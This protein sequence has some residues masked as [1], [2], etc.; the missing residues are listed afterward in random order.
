MQTGWLL[1]DGQVLAAADALDR[2]SDRAK[3][4]AGHP[5]FDGALLLAPMKI[6]HSIGVAFPLDVAFC[7]ADLRVLRTIHLERWRL[8]APNWACH[9]VIEARAGS[10]ERWGLAPGDQLEFRPAT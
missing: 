6:A 1:C 7:A 5:G 3:G 2:F 8:S 9:T 10:F 4:M